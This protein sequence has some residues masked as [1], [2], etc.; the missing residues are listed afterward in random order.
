MPA[1]PYISYFYTGSDNTPADNRVYS[2]TGDF[3][4]ELYSP[5]ATADTD[6]NKLERALNDSEVYFESNESPLKEYGAVLSSYEITIYIKES[7]E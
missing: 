5:I 2:R 6:R 3:R 7:E 1:M 4:I